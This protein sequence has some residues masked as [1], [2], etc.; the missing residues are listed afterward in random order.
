MAKPDGSL[1]AGPVQNMAAIFADEHVQTR[2]MLEQ[3]QP[4]GDNPDIQLAANPIKFMQTPTNLY[5]T[6]PK[7]GAHNDAIAAEFGFAI[8]QPE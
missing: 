2:G 4:Q 6:P 5:R 3:C 7:L 1:P 8:P